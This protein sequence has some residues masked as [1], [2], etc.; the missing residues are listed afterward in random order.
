MTV[1]QVSILLPVYGVERT[2]SD[3]LESLLSQTVQDFEI[4]CV[5]DA[6]PDRCAAILKAYAARDSRIK[7]VT[8]DKNRGLPV[9]RNSGLEQVAGDYILFVDTDDRLHHQA[10]ALTLDAMEQTGADIVAFK[11]FAVGEEQRAIREEPHYA[12]A[13]IDYVT[14]QPFK[15]MLDKKVNVFIWNKLYRRSVFGS[16]LRFNER[17][18]VSQDQGILPLIM[19]RAHRLAQL[20]NKLYYYFTGPTSLSAHVRPWTVTSH[21]LEGYLFAEYQ[22]RYPIEDSLRQ[23]FKRYTAKSVFQSVDIVFSRVP[24]GSQDETS[25]L[26][27]FVEECRKLID[28][29]T[30]SWRDFSPGRRLILAVLLM[31][32]N[33]AA[34]RRLWL[35]FRFMR[36]PFKRASG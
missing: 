28:T 19:L 10:L 30:L 24:K 12:H 18:R 26:D 8:H 4:I 9:A 33:Y 35:T 32:N 15:A 1:P 16:D 13:E 21:V 6:S 3:C 23:K 5:D 7:V 2:L 22:I 14:D 25:L 17:Q 31:F 36:N 20:K 27:L 11:P 29:R 34:A